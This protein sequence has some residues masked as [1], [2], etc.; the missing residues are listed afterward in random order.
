[1]ELIRVA[2]PKFRS[3]LLQEVRKHHWVPH[4]QQQTPVDVPELATLA[5]KLQINGE[6]FDYVRYT[7]RMNVVCRSFSTRTPKKRCNCDTTPC[8][9]A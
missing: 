1:M 7:R 3:H 2:H 5:L 6:S 4:Y 8:L 9:P